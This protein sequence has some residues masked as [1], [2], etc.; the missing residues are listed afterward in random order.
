MADTATIRSTETT[1]RLTRRDVL[2]VLTVFPVLY[3]LHGFLPDTQRLFVDNDHRA[4]GTFW[5][6]I[7]GRHCTGVAAVILAL[8]RR[9][10]TVAAL[11]LRAA[12]RKLLAVTAALVAYGIGITLLRAHL[13]PLPGL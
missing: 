8:R 1:P 11:G 7:A 10:V 3:L 2:A 13:G 6:A 12:P 4:R 9:G 5:G